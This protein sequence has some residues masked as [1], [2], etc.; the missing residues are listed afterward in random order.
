MLPNLRL[1][2]GDLSGNVELPGF[3]VGDG[4]GICHVGVD[5]LL[6]GSLEGHDTSPLLGDVLL[7]GL[8]VAVEFDAGGYL[9]LRDERFGELRFG[10]PGLFD[11]LL[12][13]FD[14]EIGQLTVST[15]G[16]SS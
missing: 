6:L 11:P 13:G 14:G 15:L 4:D 12:D 3:E 7:A 5:E 10:A 9:H 1:G 8:E 2:V 16:V